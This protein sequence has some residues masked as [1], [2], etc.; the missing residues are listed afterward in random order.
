VHLSGAVEWFEDAPRLEEVVRRLSDLHEAGRAESW[1]IEDAPRTYIDGLLRAIVGVEMRVERIE[2]KQKLSQ[3]KSAADF[4]GVMRGLAA[5]DG[6][7]REV[8]ALMA[9]VRAAAH[10]PDG[11]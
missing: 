1:R 9:L 7:S 2:A 10:D 5:S 4:D 11:N 6:E 3:N 8:A